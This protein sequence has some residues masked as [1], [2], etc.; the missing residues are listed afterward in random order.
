VAM[1]RQAVCWTDT[2]FSFSACS[3]SPA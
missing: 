1:Q 3:N 2:P